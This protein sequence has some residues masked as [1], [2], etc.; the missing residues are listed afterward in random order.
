MYTFLLGLHNLLRW[1]ILLLL[2]INIIRH[3]AA[4]NQP[5][6]AIDKK[7][8]L[9]LMI[10]AH[11]QLLVGLYEWFA[12]AW[13]LQNFINN[14]AQVM[15]NSTGR[16]FAVEHSVAMIIAIALIT[17]ARGVFRKNLTDSKKHRRCIVL[18]LLALIIIL[19]MIPWPGMDDIGRSL[20][21]KFG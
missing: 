18:Y 16:F 8:G 13:G 3:F 14:G 6:A 11:I 7:L 20:V 5:F 4:I 1:V 17:F 19:A 21:P 9:W 12:G 10:A 2:I 15:Q